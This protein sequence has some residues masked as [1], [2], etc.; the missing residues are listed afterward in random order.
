MSGD[1]GHVLE[2]EKECR[3]YIKKEQQGSKDMKA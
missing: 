2:K 1:V 3:I